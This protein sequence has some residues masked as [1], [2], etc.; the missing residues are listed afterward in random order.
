[1]RMFLADIAKLRRPLVLWLTVVQVAHWS[2][3]VNSLARAGL[4]GV[5][6]AAALIVVQRRDALS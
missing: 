3:G 2:W 1:M 5:L 4:T 6:L